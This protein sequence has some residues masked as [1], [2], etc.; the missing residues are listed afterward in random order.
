[1]HQTDSFMVN[2][3]DLDYTNNNIK[4]FIVNDAVLEYIYIK[5]RKENSNKSLF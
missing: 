5:K 3:A 1:M 4:K 2:G